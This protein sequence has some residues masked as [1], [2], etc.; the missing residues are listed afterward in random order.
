MEKSQGS[1]FEPI[2]Q[3]GKLRL[4]GQRDLGGCPRPPRLRAAG[5]LLTYPRPL[6]FLVFSL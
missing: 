5:S 1:L 2:S 3:G 4:S 6:W